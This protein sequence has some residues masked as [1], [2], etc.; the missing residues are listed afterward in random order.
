MHKNLRKY[1]GTRPSLAPLVLLTPGFWLLTSSLA[2][3][4]A[5]I[6]LMA[7]DLVIYVADSVCVLTAGTDSRSLR[8][9]S[10]AM[11]R[12][13]SRNRSDC[14]ALDD[15]SQEFGRQRRRVPS[16]RGGE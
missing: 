6:S 4:E 2:T 1:V 13:R 3:C 10:T 9:G 16:R 11:W 5:G 8:A 15:L 12:E 14:R 7:K